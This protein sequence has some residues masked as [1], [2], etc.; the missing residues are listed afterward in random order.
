MREY[1]LEALQ[2]LVFSIQ[3]DLGSG[4][5]DSIVP[6]LEDIWLS[7]LVQHFYLSKGHSFMQFASTLTAADFQS[8]SSQLKDLSLALIKHL[9]ADKEFFNLPQHSKIIGDLHES[10]DMRY[11]SGNEIIF[12]NRDYYA[13]FIC[14]FTSRFF[15][16]LEQSFPVHRVENEVMIREFIPV[17]LNAESEDEVKTYYRKLGKVGAI[18]LFLRGIDVNAEN[19]ITNMPDPILFDLECLF[20]PLH[21]KD[22]IY[23][24]RSTGLIRVNKNYDVSGLTGGRAQVN[25]YLKPILTGTDDAPKVIWEVPS[26]GKFYN[27]PEIKGQRVDPVHYLGDF[28][29]GFQLAAKHLEAEKNEVIKLVESHKIGIRIVAKATK[30]YRITQQQYYFPNIYSKIEIDS[31]LREELPKLDYIYAF[32]ESEQLFENELVA[33]KSGVIP[34]FYN[35]IHDTNVLDG[36]GNIVAKLIKSPFE[37]WKSYLSGY[38]EEVAKAI[39]MIDEEYLDEITK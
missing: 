30:N 17:Q 8:F 32:T 39:K 3:P 21:T 38:K 14:D 4:L 28:K 20:S 12:K 36:R 9:V 34:K 26:Q 6:H 2:K 5:T 29:E 16:G 7:T 25:S 33:L 11:K 37:V 27:I 13:Q 1:T 19:V 18:L 31:Y 23:S 10:G 15:P 35:E 22:T 24:F